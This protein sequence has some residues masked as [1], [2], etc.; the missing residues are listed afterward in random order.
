[1]AIKIRYQA[2]DGKQFDNQQ[3]AE[4][5]NTKCFEEWLESRPTL[6]VHSFLA[7]FDY[8]VKNE[9]YLNKREVAQHCIREYWDKCM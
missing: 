3:E 8:D 6:D 4:N 2:K 9:L 1:L 5:W 7:A